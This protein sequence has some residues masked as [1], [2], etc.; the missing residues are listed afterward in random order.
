MLE[1]IEFNT[2]VISYVYFIVNQEKNKVKSVF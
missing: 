2:K 1:K